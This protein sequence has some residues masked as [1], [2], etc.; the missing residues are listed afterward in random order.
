M[1]GRN[2][3]SGLKIV[4]ERIGDIPGSRLAHLK[5]L[6]EAAEQIKRSRHSLPPVPMGCLNQ[7]HNKGSQLL[8][9][10]IRYDYRSNAYEA[11]CGTDDSQ[12][13]YAAEEAGCGLS[14]LA[15][16]TLN[17]SMRDL[18]AGL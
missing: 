11:R 9:L 12:T 13:R 16:I 14:R 15:M 2:L 3:I 7:C 10:S 1:C 5:Y 6:R 17:S 8:N 18:E 4:L